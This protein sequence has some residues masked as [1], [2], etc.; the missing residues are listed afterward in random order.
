MKV[1][2]FFAAVLFFLI[3][4]GLYAAFTPPI[5]GWLGEPSD[6]YFLKQYHDRAYGELSEYIRWGDTV[7]FTRGLPQLPDINYR[8]PF[9]RTLVHVAAATIPQGSSFLELMVDYDPDYEAQD[10]W[11]NTP[12]MVAAEVCYQTAVAFLVKH[13]DVRIKNND[14]KTALDLATDPS[15]RF[16]PR[17]RASVIDLIAKA[18]VAS[19]D[20]EL[21]ASGDRERALRAAVVQLSMPSKKRVR[22]EADEEVSCYVCCEY[23]KNGRRL[24]MTDSPCGNEHEGSFLCGGCFDRISSLDKKCPLCFSALAKADAIRWRKIP[25]LRAAKRKKVEVS[26]ESC[27]S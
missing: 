10:V 14:D 18:H 5:E 21:E 15:R 17:Y 9:Q 11:G 25:K 24:K 6:E 26:T 2:R 19:L 7:A 3:S 8:G 16:Q 12:L 13:T 1:I 4:N 22:D 20:Q 23:E 27:E